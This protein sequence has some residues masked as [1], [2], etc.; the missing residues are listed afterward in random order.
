VQKDLFSDDA[1]PALH[2]YLT[3]QLLTYIGNKRALLGFIG[4]GVETVKERLGTEQLRTFDAFAGSGVVSRFLKLHST[5]LHANDLERYAEVVARCYLSDPATVDRGAVE[6]AVDWINDEAERNP[7]PGFI[8]ELYAPDD[9][10]DIREGERVFYTTRNA[11]FIDTARQLIDTLPADVQPYLLAP[12]LY[13]A[14][15]H[16]N[17]SGVFKGFYKNSRTGKGQFGGNGRN[18]LSRI[19]GDIRLAPPVL[20]PAPCDVRVTRQDANA[21]AKGDATGPFD[22]AYLDPPYN[23]HPYGSN[24]FMLNLIADYKRPK[25]ISRVSG[26]PRDWNRSP[27]NK[28]PAIADAL[29][30]LLAH[31]DAR[32]V[33]V[34]YNSEGFLEDD[35]MRALLAAFGP[36][37]T[38]STPY[39]AFRGSRNLAQRDTYVTEMLYL[40]E[41]AGG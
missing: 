22:L 4:Q 14:S 39:N 10:T 25:H 37:D 16:A 27:Y 32:F 30:D 11:R 5:F 20:H 21:V 35:A 24:Y 33:L 12:L 28:R 1:P 17:T 41:K 23:Q 26:I 19:L 38:I 8:Q 7:R 13:E 34:S 31:L 2:A 18:A 40:L 36:V 9:D 3:D 15:V 6:E 29:R